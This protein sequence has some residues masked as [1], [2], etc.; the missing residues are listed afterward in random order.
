MHSLE[1]A[2]RQFLYQSLT[3]LGSI[4][5]GATAAQ[6]NPLAPKKPHYS[7]KARSCI[8]LT[9][10]GGVSHMDTFDPKPA[11][12]RLDNTVMDWS[13]EKATDQANL[14]A[15]PRLILG[16]PF[17]FQKHGQC[18]RDVSEL[19]PHVAGCVDDLAFVR[20]IQTENGNHPAAV[21]LMNT[22]FVMPGRPS[23][24]AWVTYGLGTQN[25][26]LPGFVVLPDFRSLTFSGSQQ[27]GSGFLPASYQGTMLRWKGDPIQDLTP[28]K[29]VTP[30]MQSAEMDLL[31]GLNRR[32]LETHLTNPDL[33]GRIDS[34]ELAYRMQMEVPGTLNVSKEPVAIREMYGLDDSNTESF[35]TRC[36]MAR[37]L[38]EKGVRFVQLYTPSQSWDSHTDLERRH[39]QNAKEVDQPIAALIKDLKQRGLLDSTLIVWMGEF[40]RT[41]DCP[42]DLRDKAGRDH[43]TRAMT[44]W[45]AGGGTKPGAITGETDD[46]GFKAVSNIYRMRDVHATVL[47][48]MGLD[49]S[50]LTFYHAGR[51]MRLTDTGGR[52]IKEVLA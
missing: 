46:L 27:W 25:Q 22:G 23:M 21:F 10:L 39:R 9:M 34:Y 3:G 31:R 49:E 11:L 50:R 19:F 28:P 42:S 36:V 35:G 17:K 44:I 8:F 20:S 51:N 30:A 33:Q 47:H 24:G 13:K 5:L 12:A 43:N 6:E 38:V 14:F 26:N 52:V 16:S 18:G 2:R 48:L 40:G 15:K 32:H 37:Q 4:A 45:F 29:D 1:L 41:P 7:P